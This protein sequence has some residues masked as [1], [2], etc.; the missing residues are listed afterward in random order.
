MTIEE[1]KIIKILKGG[2][3]IKPTDKEGEDKEKEGEMEKEKEKRG[4]GKLDGRKELAELLGV[5]DEKLVPH[6]V[7]EIS[8]LLCIGALDVYEVGRIADILK[9]NDG[10]HHQQRKL[11][12]S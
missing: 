5:E 6:L 10:I 12:N 9:K 1:H 7:L 8:L 11:Y 4:P 3:E 2:L